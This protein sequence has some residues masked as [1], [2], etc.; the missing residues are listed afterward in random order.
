VFRS[1]SDL[2]CTRGSAGPSGSGAVRGIGYSAEL[3]ADAPDIDRAFLGIRSGN[4]VP[5]ANQC[6][7][8]LVQ[9][10]MTRAALLDDPFKHG[11]L[12][13]SNMPNGKI[14]CVYRASERWL[15]YPG[16]KFTEQAMCF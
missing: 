14:A 9:E 7:F 13:D 15:K 3:Q 10:F 1:V 16:Q 8:M 12:P 11:F 5:F 2:R 4:G 6:A